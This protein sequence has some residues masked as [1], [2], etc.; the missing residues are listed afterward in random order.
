MT[1]LMIIFVFVAVAAA[2]FTIGAALM[3]PSSVVGVRLQSMLGYRAEPETPKVSERLEKVL[4]PFAKAMPQSPE[5]ASET[6]LLL[7]QAGYREMRHVRIYL[8]IRVLAAL[9]AFG[10]V[11]GTGM[12]AKSLL[13]AVAAPALGFMLP[14]FMLKRRVTRRQESIRL[15]LPDALDL[16]IICVEAGLGLDQALDRIAVEIKSA[17]PELSDEMELVTLEIRAGKPREEALRNLA[18]RTGVDDIR[19]FVA[20]LIQTDRFGTSIAMALRVHSD[21]LR[22]ERRQRAEERAAK[23]TIK[24]IPVLVLFIFPVM[25]FVI[26]GPV[27]I[28]ISRDI[29][30]AMNHR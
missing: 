7:F 6:R 19:A 2:F 12:A 11:V 13:L 23:T 26:L 5:G 27:V 24:M 21:A 17:H 28:Q 20:V 4:E 30:P 1:M 16:A 3:A 9:L 15:A 10:V 8:G 22:T 25:F 29:L 18:I 14:Q